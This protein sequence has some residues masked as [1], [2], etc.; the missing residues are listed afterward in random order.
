MKQSVSPETNNRSGILWIF[1]L[2]LK[3]KFHYHI[4]KPLVSTHSLMDQ[5]HIH[6]PYLFKNRFNI[7][8]L[9]ERPPLVS[10]VSA[11]FSG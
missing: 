3:P 7:V 11:N 6:I 8:T 2:L 5:I 10:E 4:H 1:L 9:T